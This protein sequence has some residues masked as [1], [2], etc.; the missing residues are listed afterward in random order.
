MLLDSSPHLLVV[1]RGRPLADI[2][3]DRCR[4]SFEVDT[5]DFDTSILEQ[6][7]DRYDLL[8]LDWNLERPDARGVL[9]AFRQR[10]PESWVLALAEE[11]PSDDPVDRGADDVLVS[12]FSAETLRTTIDRLLLQRAYAETMNELFRLSTERA[13][14][15]NELQSDADVTDRYRSV[16]QDLREYRERAASI[17]DELSDEDF[18]RTLRQLF[19]K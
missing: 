7:D 9:D 2:D 17:R 1:H 6:L 16:M 13:L 18:D 3:R 4:V 14:L 15:E 10:A 19:K 12:P 5:A 11:V 8:V